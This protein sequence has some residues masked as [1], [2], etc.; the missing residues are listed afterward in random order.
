MVNTGRLD[1]DL[2]ALHLRY[3]RGPRSRER[4]HGVLDGGNPGTTWTVCSELTE[5][6]WVTL[7][8]TR[9]ASQ[10]MASMSPLIAIATTFSAIFWSWVLFRR[11][12]LTS[13]F[14]RMTEN[15]T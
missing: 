15:L 5:M 11:S 4:V 10:R 9:S 6:D 7:P 2:G 13:S 12:T 1:L 3:L 8:S 14:W